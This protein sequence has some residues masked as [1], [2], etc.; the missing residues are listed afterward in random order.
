MA[1][2]GKKGKEERVVRGREYRGR[3]R[4]SAAVKKPPQWIVTSIVICQ[5]RTNSLV[6]MRRHPPLGLLITQ[7]QYDTCKYHLEVVWTP[8]NNATPLIYVLHDTPKLNFLFSLSF[9]NVFGHLY[10]CPNDSTDP[11]TQLLWHQNSTQRRFKNITWFYNSFAYVT[12]YIV[13]PSNR[14]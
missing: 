1:K 3:T 9:F 12:E 10:I 5:E 7:S 13:G 8:G 2:E 11:L 4:L 14:A 6:P